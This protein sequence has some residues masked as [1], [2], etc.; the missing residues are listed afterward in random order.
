MKRVTQCVLV[1]VVVFG[2]VFVAGEYATWQQ[3]TQQDAVVADQAAAPAVPEGSSMAWQVEGAGDSSYNG[4]Y[5][6]AGTYNGETYYTYEGDSGTRYLYY[7]EEE[8][9]PG[10]GTYVYTWGL[11][12]SL[13]G[14]QN[15]YGEEDTPLPGGSWSTYPGYEPAPTVSEYAPPD[16][17]PEPDGEEL[18]PPPTW[19]AQARLERIDDTTLWLGQ[20]AISVG[21]TGK[22]YTYDVTGDSWT[23]TT[24]MSSALAGATSVDSAAY[25]GTV[26]VAMMSGGEEVKLYEYDPSGDTWTL[27]VTA[28]ITDLRSGSPLTVVATSSNVYILA[29]LTDSGGYTRWGGLEVS[30]ADWSTTDLAIGTAVLGVHEDIMLTAAVIDGD[31]YTLRAL[32]TTD[33]YLRVYG[34]DGSTWTPEDR[35]WGVEVGAAP[36]WGSAVVDD[37]DA[38]YA[39]NRGGT[40]SPVR[41]HVDEAFDFT[42]FTAD[43]LL[44]L[45]ANGPSLYVLHEEHASAR[46]FRRLDTWPATP[47]VTVS[48]SGSDATISW[49]FEDYDLPADAQSAYRL[50]IEADDGTSVYDSGKTTG[51]DS[52]H[53]ETGLADDG[54]TAAVTVFDE[55][56]QMSIAGEADFQVGGAP[57]TDSA[58]T[59][60]ISSPSD[61]ATVYGDTTITVAASDDNGV[62]RVTIAVDGEVLATL[63]EA[64]DGSD[65]SVEWDVSDVPDG[66]HTITATARDTVG[67]TAT[68]SH[69]V[70]LDADGDTTAPTVSISTPSA[71]ATVGGDVTVTAAASDD[72]GVT[73]VRLL[74]DG[75]LQDTLTAA[76]DGSDYT[77][78]WDTDGWANGTHDIRVVAYDQARNFSYDEVSVTL[79]RSLA[80]ETL[81]FFT[82]QTP[83]AAVDALWRDDVQAEEVVVTALL[84]EDVPTDEFARYQ[85]TAGIHVPG[86]SVDFD[87]YQV[88]ELDRVSRLTTP[89]S[90][91]R[92]ALRAAPTMVTAYWEI[93]ETTALRLLDV[94][95]DPGPA[96]F[97]TASDATVYRLSSD[98]YSEVR[99]VALASPED[100]AVFGDGQ[101][102]AAGEELYVVD[103][104]T[105]ELTWEAKLPSATA[106][107]AVGAAGDTVL[108]G[109]DTASSHLVYQFSFS[110]LTEVAEVAD[111]VN[112]IELSEGGQAAALALADGTVQR[113]SGGSSLTQLVDTEEASANAILEV[114]DLI[115]LGTGTDGEVWVSSPDW[116][117]D[118]ALGSGTVQALALWNDHVLAA[119]IGDGALWRRSGG[120]WTQWYT[121]DG[122]SRIND[123]LV[124]DDGRLW[125]AATHSGGARVYRLEAAEVGDIECSS[126]PPDVVARPVRMA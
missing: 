102:F 97:C 87:D 98:G 12:E 56:E 122:V 48:V 108:V 73:E 24:A 19:M 100:A 58:P 49:T 46:Y 5:Y 30:T 2:L 8:T 82:H 40:A 42:S 93:A 16:N 25:G 1:F 85:V 110:A 79:D 70:T 69:T 44:D 80:L 65:Y 20:W 47:E 23:E 39:W 43:G 45:A 105:G 27:R 103:L 104:D 88:V 119:G 89:A 90:T 67:Q 6:S 7:T 36:G 29:T 62:S 72:V 77:F 14:Q 115:Y 53:T 114:N 84:R 3:Q 91:F 121:F 33:N 51:T 124:D 118:A 22:S 55:D 35:A 71:G 10:S 50:T 32:I 63:T 52:S 109:V 111:T 31:S 21:S 75:Q 113:W 68:D 81:Y 4:I 18:T 17:D 37:F 101:I 76:N 126:E 38:W 59:V 78:T 34:W 125:V 95:G 26:Y 86:T 54:Y 106:Y 66:Q 83:F 41:C 74:V 117:L 9:P 13:G 60:S 15:Y 57:A 61:A 11:A 112:A 94:A 92:L 120:S 28:D 96:A 107:T 123:L 116:A 64:N 99:S